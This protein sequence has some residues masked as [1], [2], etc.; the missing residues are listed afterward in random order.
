[1][2]RLLL[3]AFAALIISGCAAIPGI[4]D[5][6]TGSYKEQGTKTPYWI[7]KADLQIR[8]DGK[9]FAG[10]GATLAHGSTDIDVTSLVGIDRAEVETCDREDVCQPGVQCDSKKFIEVDKGW[11]GQ[12]GK[13]LVY[14]FNPSPKEMEGPC[15]LQIRVF[16]KA[17]LLAWGFLGFRN[18]E[19]LPAHFVCNA[20]PTLFA[21]HS[22]CNPKAGKINQIFFDVAIIDFDADPSCH[23]T[24]L[25][26]KHFELRPEMGLCTAKFFDGKHWHGID[27]IAY[28][29]VLVR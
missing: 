27:V 15:L 10:A 3:G 19:D 18:G 22:V 8:V 21:G 1:M 13:H 9:T 5:V 11:F 16:N 17:A 20:E 24:K 26:D 12:P 4:W 29:E 7:Y 23:M 6:I 28:D 14:R 2:F 25:D